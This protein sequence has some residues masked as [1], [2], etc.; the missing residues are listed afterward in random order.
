MEATESYL[1]SVK[2]QFLYYKMLGEKA[3]AQLEPEQLFISVNEDT[4]SI[5]AIVKHI[6][7]NMLSRW[8]DFLTSDGEK[9]WRNRDAEFE[10]DLQS[11]EE[12]ILVWNKGWDVFLDTLNSLKPEQL[13]EIIYIR[14]EGHTVIE[15]VNRQLA[16]YPYHVGQIVFYAKQLKN[17]S[18]DSLSI[19]RN[20]SG[21]YNAEKFAKEKEIKNFT[22]DE[23]KRLK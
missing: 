20:K 4:N 22:D 1:E 11:K 16:H 6:S 23:L 19:P 17:S 8:T 12:V 14:N 9:E 2:K 15:A 7:G 10:N 18:W 5:A 3:M 13:S 21:N